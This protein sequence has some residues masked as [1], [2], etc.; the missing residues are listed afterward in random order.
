M[1]EEKSCATLIRKLED[2]SRRKSELE[3]LIQDPKL[4]ADLPRYRTILRELGGLNR[5][6]DL[7]QEW[8]DKAKQ[9]G[10]LRELLEA[11]Q[12]AELLALARAEA[13]DLAKAK[14][15][16]IQRIK[17]MLL[18]EDKDSGRSA[19][20]EVRAGTGGD[21]A[22][23]FA[24]SLFRMYSRY[25]ERKGWRVEALDASV[26]DLGGFKEVIF[27][28]S[29]HGV[30]RDLR[31][32]S[33]GHRVQRVPE[34]E[35]QGRIHT[36]LVTVA[37]LPEVED[38]EIDLN[39]SDIKMDTYRAG[40]PGG[41]NVNKTSSAVRLTHIPTGTVVQCQD[42]SS[43]H[44]NRAK[45]MRVLRA[46]LYEKFETEQKAARDQ[47]R[48]SQIGSGDRSERIRTYNFPQDRVTDHRLN[49]NFHDIEGLLGGNLEPLVAR[50]RERDMDLRLSEL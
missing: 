19:I 20:I 23:L 38:V 27:S 6:A 14:D 11:E 32:E 4:I 39:P 9:E 45:A 13:Q 18:S 26:N 17:E 10:D 50:L 35:S 46:R 30:F 42:E 8:R 21:E 36:S 3:T 31:Y 1:L 43:Q 7:L 34:T 49:E 41:Q 40:G 48:R 33:G 5:A 28:I 16:L 22:A 12:D 37:V 2:L 29:G 47:S 24:G 44:K 15:G 25:A